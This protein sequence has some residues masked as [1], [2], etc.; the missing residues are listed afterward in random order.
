MKENQRRSWVD[1]IVII[2]W[3]NWENLQMIQKIVSK[4]G[5]EV[6]VKALQSDLQK[7]FDWSADSQMFFNTGKSKAIHFGSKNKEADYF[8]GCSKLYAVEDESYNRQNSKAEWVVYSL[9]ACKQQ[10]QLLQ[11]WEWQIK[12]I[13]TKSYTVIQRKPK[14][15]PFLAAQRS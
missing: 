9:P 13:E 14:S 8:L 2:D 5:S 11:F 6:A 4:S 1:L 15:G 10:E 7:L 3:N 12:K